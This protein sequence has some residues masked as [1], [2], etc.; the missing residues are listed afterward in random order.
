[1]TN[2]R[3]GDPFLG[4]E[5]VA[6]GRVSRHGLR[7]AHR[8]LFPRVYADAAGAPDPDMLV[9]AAALWAPPGAVVC[10]LA[11]ARVH[12]ERWYSPESVLREIEVYTLAPTHAP[13]GIRTRRLRTPLSG[14][15]VVRVSGIEVTSAARTAIDVARWDDDDE[16]AIA[17]VDA[18]CNRSRTDVSEVRSL[19]SGL[20]GL[21]GIARVRRLLSSC[22]H[23]ADSPPETR[24]RLILNRSELPRAVPQLTI[25]NEYGVVVTVAD[26]GYPDQRVAVFYDGEVH[27]RRTNWE[28][29][30]RVNA[31]LAELGWQVI[32]VTAQMLRS[33]Q[34]VVRQISVA[35]E[36]G[37]AAP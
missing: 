20:R 7:A 22:D 1:M 4:G 15:Q 5:A 25:Y 14:D 29:D 12:G 8:R 36:R 9:R 11:A 16:R 13:P 2:G 18:V 26:F 23:R 3:P 28:S 33:H 34:T 10:G 37:R 19:A 30:A 32:R 17:K 6:S 31:G 24:F 27:R 35:V 21:Q